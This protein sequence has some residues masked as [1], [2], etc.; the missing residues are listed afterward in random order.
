MYL[1]NSSL[2]LDAKGRMMVPSKYRDALQKEC[3]GQ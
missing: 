1:G 3:E 2:S